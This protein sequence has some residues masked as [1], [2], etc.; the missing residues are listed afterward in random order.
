MSNLKKIVKSI[1]SFCFA[2]VKCSAAARRSGIGPGGR[3]S[4]PEE[5]FEN[6][7]YYTPYFPAL[8]PDGCLGAERNH[9]EVH[10]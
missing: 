5:P 8:R 9:H 3:F 2:P 10:G 7:V 4:F 1:G 6:T